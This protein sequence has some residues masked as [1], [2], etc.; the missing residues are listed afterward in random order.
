MGM[1]VEWDP[2]KDAANVE[3]HGITF[4]DAKRVFEDSQH[5]TEES[6]RADYGELRKLAIGRVGSIM[7]TVV[8]TDRQDARR[9]I[10]AR[11]ARRDERER[12]RQSA[13]A[14]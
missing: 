8:Y 12:Y 4:E 6:T 3:K 7:V 11:R 13:E 14:V 9:I 1:E 10:S 2:A 5:I